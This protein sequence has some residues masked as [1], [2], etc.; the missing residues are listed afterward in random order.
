MPVVPALLARVQ[1]Q[2]RHPY[3]RHDAPSWDEMDASERFA[4]AFATMREAFGPPAAWQF[5]FE[6][7][8]LAMWV[9]P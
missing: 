1:A 9:V 6:V 2:R 7:A 3:I 8:E 5:W 4:R